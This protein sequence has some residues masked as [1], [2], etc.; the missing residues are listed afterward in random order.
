MVTTNVVASKLIPLVLLKPIVQITSLKCLPFQLCLV[1]LRKGSSRNVMAR[2][3]RVYYVWNL[4]HVLPLNVDVM[5]FEIFFAHPKD[6]L[7]SAAVLNVITSLGSIIFS[8]V[9]KLYLLSHCCGQMRYL[10]MR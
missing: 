1:G 3:Q 8:Y 9:R 2:F 4:I 5:S 7:S 6:P 10:L